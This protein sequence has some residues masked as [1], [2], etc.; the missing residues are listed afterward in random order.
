M[1]KFHKTTCVVLTLI[2]FLFTLSSCTPNATPVTKSAFFF[3]TYINI[4]FY[5]DK[6]AQKFSGCETLCRKY[7]NM[8]SR[9]VSGSDIERI[10][11]AKGE[12][13]EV[14]AECADLIRDALSFCEETNGAVDI[15]IA[16][17]MDAWDFTGEEENK[18]PPSLE[19]IDRLLTHVNY[20]N[21]ETDG[22]KV[23]ITDPE[24]AIDLGFIA[25]GFIAD[26]IKEYLIDQNVKSALINLGGNIQLVGSKPDGGDYNIGVQKPF[27][28]NGEYLTTVSIKDTSLVTSGIY[29]RCFTYQERLYHHILDPRTGYPIENGLSQVTILCTSSETADALSTSLM[30]LGK[31]KGTELL[32]K[33]DAHA[34]FTLSDD[35][36]EY[37]PDFPE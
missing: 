3:N 9:T 31:E 25:K 27:S 19:E 22:N 17:L 5:S 21:V 33:Y 28:Q 6:D 11:S 37:S 16:P 1:R 8:L 36:L 23:R 35:T 18:T 14:D 12:W 2:L 30:L 32:S 20:K 34:I 15:T 7:E 13:V 10:N 24:A 29:E 26:R 4:T